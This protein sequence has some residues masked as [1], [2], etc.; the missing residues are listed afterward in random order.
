MLTDPPKLSLKSAYPLR[1][2]PAR[3]LAEGGRN[4]SQQTNWN[5]NGQGAT[6]DSAEYKAAVRIVDGFPVEYSCIE[7]PRD[8]DVEEMDV[9]ELVV[10]FDYEMM[11]RIY[12]DA[13]KS[14]RSLEWSLLWNVASNLGLHNCNY[15]KQHPVSETRRRLSASYV[16][17]LSSLS[18]DEIDL[19]TS[20]NR[21]LAFCQN[22]VTI[23]DSDSQIC[24][25]Y[26]AL[27]DLGELGRQT[28]N[29]HSDERHDDS[30]LHW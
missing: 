1:A 17:G 22:C 4:S 8:S 28:Y 7:D 20:K 5:G 21:G 23:G 18:F 2:I 29:L 30:Q 25:N 13:E 19:E 27:Y 6:N 3:E 12:A 9:K 10:K 14:R 15:K 26:R 16:I 11:T 24:A